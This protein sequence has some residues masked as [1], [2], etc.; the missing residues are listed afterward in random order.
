MSLYIVLNR[1]LGKQDMAHSCFAPSRLGV[2]SIS[3]LQNFSENTVTFKPFPYLVIENAL[4]EDMFDT[5]QQTYPSLY[6]QGVSIEAD[7]QRWSTS[8]LRG[9]E[10]AGLHP[11]W[12]QL[13]EYHVSN[14]FLCEVCRAF[15]PALLSNYPDRFPNREAF[16]ALRSGIRGAD[17]S[18]SLDLWMDAQICGNTPARTAGS[19]R[20]VH[21]DSTTA[22]YGG[23]Y[24]LRDDSDD[25]IGGDLQLWKWNDG[26]SYG[27]KS[28]QYRE[29]VPDRH[30]DL[31]RTVP[32]K[33]NTLVMF[34]NTID[35]LHS[36][37]P[38]LPTPH[39]RKFF[40]LLAD[41]EYAYFTLSPS[42]LLRLRNLIRRRVLKA[43]D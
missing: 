35:S 18:K 1:N 21:L 13:I 30:V 10:I 11:L 37:T 26:F 28:G 14:E 22:L 25:S 12:K 16:T 23:L 2:V 15:E 31:V 27:K 40:N 4:P 36:V 32:Y 29:G 41:S 19:P 3:L 39:T 42:P 38:R 43:L 34:I 8:A 7:N 17:K 24:Y 33:A 9:L 20:G 6:S 5:L